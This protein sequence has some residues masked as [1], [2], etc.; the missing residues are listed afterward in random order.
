MDIKNDTRIETHDSIFNITADKS[1]TSF[2]NLK[3]GECYAWL[4]PV[5]QPHE[6]EYEEE[7]KNVIILQGNASDIGDAYNKL[8]EELRLLGVFNGRV[9]MSYV[10]GRG[11]K[12]R[13]KFSNELGEIIVVD[14]GY[15]I[16]IVCPHELEME[17]LAAMSDKID[18]QKVERDPYFSRLTDDDF[19]LNSDDDRG[20]SKRDTECRWERDPDCRSR[21]KSGHISRSRSRSR[22]RLG[23]QKAGRKHSKKR[24]FQK[25]IRRSKKNKRNYHNSR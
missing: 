6:D 21:S 14:E 10:E 22:D 7:S 23:G 4:P 20:R 3:I 11:I 8:K 15:F 13:G 5:T 17:Q 12:H 19:E 25:K 1:E 18:L 16:N 9:G 24:T 2:F